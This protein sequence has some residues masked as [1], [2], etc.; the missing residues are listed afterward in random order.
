MPV[1]AD[2]PVVITPLPRGQPPHGVAP[3]RG[4]L[5]R[6][7]EVPV[8]AEQQR[9]LAPGRRPALHDPGQ[10]V[11]HHRVP[12]AD[13]EASLPGL[14]QHA[15]RL[16]RL[17]RRL[18]PVIGRRERGLQVRH[19]RLDVGGHRPVP[20]GFIGEARQPRGQVGRSRGVPRGQPGERKPLGGGGT[21]GVDAHEADVLARRV[22]VIVRAHPGQ[23]VDRVPGPVQAVAEQTG[24]LHGGARSTLQPGVNQG[25]AAEVFLPGDGRE[26]LVRDLLQQLQAQRLKL[27]GAMRGLPQCQHPGGGHPFRENRLGELTSHR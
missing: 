24:G 17:G 14:L 13:T 16:P 3:D 22:L 8:V 19:G 9:A 15:P 1:G 25:D 4:R 5:P 7:V 23:Q 26:A 12:V 21:R 11:E 20:Q 2:H 18:A 6:A 27:M 10:V